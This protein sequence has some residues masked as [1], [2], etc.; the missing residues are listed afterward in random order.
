MQ[1]NARISRPIFKKDFQNEILNNERV[2]AELTDFSGYGSSL[3]NK[4]KESFIQ[5]RALLLNDANIE[6]VSLTQNLNVKKSH[7]SKI[8]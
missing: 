4:Q 6:R 3:N 1:Q 5:N 2:M 7:L 8:T